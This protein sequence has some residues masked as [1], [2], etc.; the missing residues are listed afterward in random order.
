[1]SYDADHR[2]RILEAIRSACVANE[3]ERAATLLQQ[4][5]AT[6][7]TKNRRIPL[8]TLRSGIGATCA[9]RLV[10][11]CTVRPCMYCQ[12]GREQCE[13]CRGTGQEQHAQ[14]CQD[15]GGFGMRRCPFCNG[16]SFAGYD[17]VPEGLRVAIMSGRLRLALARIAKLRRRDPASESDRDKLIR[18]VID[19]DR[20]RGVLANAFE[21]IGGGD[22]TTPGAALYAQS[23]VT[24]VQFMCKAANA[25]AESV[26]RKYLH[27]LAAGSAP[28]LPT[29]QGNATGLG[30]S[31]A[32]ATHFASLAR[33]RHLAPSALETPFVFRDE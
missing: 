16:T 13:S 1:M 26:I 3:F 30:V 10:K 22:V 4:A 28:A 6:L 2:D 18:E 27:A 32:R 25:T 12:G 33:D 17:F 31:S 19:L 14:F 7:K 5:A 8:D 15:C 20:C 23:T 11:W 21:H 29:D 9:D 24:R